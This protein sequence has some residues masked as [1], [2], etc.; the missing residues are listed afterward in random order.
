MPGSPSA[1][2]SIPAFAS[3]SP[4]ISPEVVTSVGNSS[5][6]ADTL[7]PAGNAAIAPLHVP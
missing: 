7:A 6:A 5:G 3:S 4:L 2:V 1:L